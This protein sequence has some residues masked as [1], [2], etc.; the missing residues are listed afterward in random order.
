[1]GE[2]D[3]HGRENNGTSETYLVE[4]ERQTR[5]KRQKSGGLL[6]KG[7]EARGRRDVARRCVG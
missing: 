1:M 5:S 7:D 4:A 3:E 6:K 2:S